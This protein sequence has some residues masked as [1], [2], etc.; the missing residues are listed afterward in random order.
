MMSRCK[1]GPKK[2]K[3]LKKITGRRII[4][5]LVRGG[6]PHGYALV[7]FEDDPQPW[8]EWPSLINYRTGEP[9]PPSKYTIDEKGNE[10]S[11]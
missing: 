4:Q 7:E 8:E 1:L 5:A 6:W 9:Q 2:V 10:I 3:H 11:G